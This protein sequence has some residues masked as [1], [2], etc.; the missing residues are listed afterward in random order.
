MVLSP[1]QEVEAVEDD[2]YE[3]DFFN[4]YN[5]DEV[6]IIEENINERPVEEDLNGKFVFMKEAKIVKFKVDELKDEL[7]NGAYQLVVKG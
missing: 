6:S 4:A 2:D 1:D 3:S 5:D 7:K